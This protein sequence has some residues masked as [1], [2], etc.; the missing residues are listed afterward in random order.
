MSLDIY[1]GKLLLVYL[2]RPLDLEA[3]G[4]MRPLRAGSPGAICPLVEAPV[5]AISD[6]GTSLSLQLTFSPDFFTSR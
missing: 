6:L 1:F 2:M 5:V 3:L 4:V